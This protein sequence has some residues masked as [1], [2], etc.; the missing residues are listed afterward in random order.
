MTY[1]G[2]VR[3]PNSLRCELGERMPWERGIF[4][5]WQIVAKIFIESGQLRTELAFSTRDLALS[6]WPTS[7]KCT[8]CGC[9]AAF[10]STTS[11]GKF[12]HQFGIFTQLYFS[13]GFLSYLFHIC[14]HPFSGCIHNQTC[15]SFKAKKWPNKYPKFHCRLWHK[16]LI[17]SGQLRTEL[18]FS[19]RE[20]A[21]S[22]WPTS[23][24]CTGCGCGAAFLPSSHL[25]FPL[26]SVFLSDF[27][28][29][30]F[31]IFHIY[32]PSA[33]VSLPLIWANLSIPLCL[34]VY[35]NVEDRRSIIFKVV[36]T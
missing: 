11:L 18:T 20:L 5:P 6:H 14:F 26:N 33:C 27:M 31:H 2:I 16:I 3:F 21:L 12:R 28:L 15:S 8:G 1:L 32:F 4:L 30:F 34:P 10:L 23:H 22:R 9:R 36:F 7:H 19:T 29:D 17:E 25:G 35:S 13:V 24:K